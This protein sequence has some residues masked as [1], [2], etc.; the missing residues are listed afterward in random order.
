LPDN[1]YQVK[2]TCLGVI[3]N[4]SGKIGLLINGWA[5]KPALDLMPEVYGLN[6]MSGFVNLRE[7]V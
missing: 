1:Y 4:L 2:V 5:T 6:W 3:I 7:S